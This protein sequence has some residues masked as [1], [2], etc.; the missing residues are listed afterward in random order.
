MK[1][2]FILLI[3]GLTMFA[4][5]K[6]DEKTTPPIT[7]NPTISTTTCA[8]STWKY[9]VSLGTPVAAGTFQIRYT[10]EFGTYIIDTTVT[11]SWTKSFTMQYAGNPVGL[12]QPLVQV[13]PGPSGMQTVAQGGN[14]VNTIMVTILQNGNIV[15]TTGTPYQYCYGTVSPCTVANPGIQKNHTCND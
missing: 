6:E 15:Q 3:V 7:N 2:L 13:E 10:D 4:C 8:N 5:S 11:S 9:E 12:Y 14:I 1:N